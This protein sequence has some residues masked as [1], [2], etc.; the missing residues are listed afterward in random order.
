LLTYSITHNKGTATKEPSPTNLDNYYSREAIF[1][2]HLASCPFKIGD[3]VKYKKPKRNPPQGTIID[4]VTDFK[5]V[6]WTPNGASPMF[7]LVKKEGSNKT[8]TNP[9]ITPINMKRLLLVR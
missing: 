1:R 8:I 3:K 4:I 7:I 5:D 2:R 9:E 6:V